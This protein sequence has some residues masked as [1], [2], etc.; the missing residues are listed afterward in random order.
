MESLK[1]I[2]NSLESLKKNVFK[3]TRQ[4][5]GFPREQ[6]AVNTISEIDMLI[7]SVEKLDKE[8]DP[9]KLMGQTAEIHHRL[10]NVELAIR[11][12][13]ELVGESD[14]TPT[15]GVL[16]VEGIRDAVQRSRESRDSELVAFVAESRAGR[17]VDELSYLED[18]AEQHGFVYI[19]DD[20]ELMACDTVTLVDLMTSAEGVGYARALKDRAI[21]EGDD[22]SRAML[23]RMFESARS[24]LTRK[25]LELREAKALLIEFG[26]VAEMIRERAL[27]EAAHGYPITDRMS[28]LL[29]HLEKVTNKGPW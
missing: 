16:T 27:F 13:P 29:T 25:T 2:A 7:K 17:S 1:K 15:G 10:T 26:E 24:H 9:A 4:P 6:I 23:I 5:G 8:T 20:A 28:E 22:R 3:A 18:A 14:P 21:P 12:N 11:E 19:D